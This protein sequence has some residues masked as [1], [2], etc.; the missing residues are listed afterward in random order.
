MKLRRGS[1]CEGGEASGGLGSQFRHR[2]CKLRNDRVCSCLMM[3]MMMMTEKKGGFSMSV[4]TCVSVTLSSG[5]VGCSKWQY[6]GNTVNVTCLCK[7][8]SARRCLQSKWAKG[9][10][11]LLW[12]WRSTWQH[13]L[14]SN[15]SAI[16]G[17]RLP[18]PTVTVMLSCADC[19]CW[20]ARHAAYATQMFI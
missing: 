15:F 11:T 5:N 3:M 8:D 14:R 7:F 6:V 19:V 12:S 20:I 10:V 13:L 18:L 1:H 2:W 16:T 17:S 9:T 4:L